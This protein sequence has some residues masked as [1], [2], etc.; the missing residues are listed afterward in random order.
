MRQTDGAMGGQRPE[1]ADVNL[2]QG[3]GHTQVARKH[4]ETTG[5][6]HGEKREP[7]STSH[8]V[9]KPTAGG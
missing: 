5:C 3:T 7:E 4:P 6:P 2:P 1:H 8:H 9:P